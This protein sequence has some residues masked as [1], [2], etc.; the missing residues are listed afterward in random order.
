MH[1]AVGSHNTENRQPPFISNMTKD[2]IKWLRGILNELRRISPPEGV[3]INRPQAT[4]SI[5]TP[6]RPDSPDILAVPASGITGYDSIPI[7][8]ELKRLANRLWVV[9]D[10]DTGTLFAISTPDGIHWTGESEIFTNEFRLFTG[11]WE[12]RLRSPN[13]TL[14]YRVSEFEIGKLV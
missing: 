10:G 12:L 8:T 14:K 5:A 7:Y 13:A 4:V 11:V 6:A 1:T 3:L 9:N 2:I